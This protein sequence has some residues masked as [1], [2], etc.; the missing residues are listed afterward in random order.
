[1]RIVDHDE[2][3]TAIKIALT[4]MRR[5]ERRELGTIGDRAIDAATQRVMRCL[6]GAVILAPDLV[7]ARN[8]TARWG[9]VPGK[10]G[11]TEPWPFEEGCRPP[12]KG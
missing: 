11:Q 3:A 9:M 10:F 2:L 6:N 7:E 8:G 1:M 5:H 12:E 4:V